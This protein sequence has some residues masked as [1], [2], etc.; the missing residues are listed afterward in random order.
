M[1]WKMAQVPQISEARFLVAIGT[2]EQTLAGKAV[3]SGY[4]QMRRSCSI[5][6]TW[7]GEG[8]SD[9]MMINFPLSAFFYLNL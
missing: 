1:A 9:M 3:S 6:R 7:K 4:K 2:G 5:K 8:D